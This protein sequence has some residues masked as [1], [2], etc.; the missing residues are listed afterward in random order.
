MSL[1]AERDRLDASLVARGLSWETRDA[2]WTSVDSIL[3]H[4]P[5]VTDAQGQTGLALGYVQS[6]KTTAITAL[7][8]AAA[9]TGYR[10]VVAIL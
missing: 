8:A 5:T 4:G 7:V 10:I 2:L 1:S 9:D 6:G 3:S